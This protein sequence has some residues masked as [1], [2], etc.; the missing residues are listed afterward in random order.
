MSRVLIIGS[1]IPVNREIG[2]AL[3]AAG[4]SKEYS[5]GLCFMGAAEVGEARFHLPL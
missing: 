3:T 1:H 4:L 2:D 5:A